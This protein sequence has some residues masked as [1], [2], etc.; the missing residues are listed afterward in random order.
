MCSRKLRLCLMAFAATVLTAGLAWALGFSL[1]ETKEQLKLK[2][3]VSSENHGGRVSITLTITDEGRL[4]PLTSV[5][6]AVPSK[7][8]PGC[9]DLSLSLATNSVDGKQV[10][11]VHLKRELAERAEFWL[12]TWSL[13]G[14][15]GS[16]TWYYHVI[17]IA[18]YLKGGQGKKD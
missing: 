17:P 1:S 12:K 3:D 6:L 2:Y 13:D 5:D 15:K 4:K 9:F 10:A 18:Q 16:L 7:N 8:E 11:M 14:K